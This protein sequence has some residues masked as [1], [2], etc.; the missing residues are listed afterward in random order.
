MAIIRAGKP[1]EKFS[2]VR[3][4]VLQDDRLS[5]R[6]RGVL[7]SILSRPDNWRCS[8]WDLALDGKEGRDA[9]LTALTELEEFGYL[10]RVKR[11]DD[12]GRWSTSSYV[13]DLPVDKS[14][15]SVDKWL[16]SVDK[17]VDNPVDN[18][19]TEVGKPE[20]GKPN[21]ENPTLLKELDK[22]LDKPPIPPKPRTHCE[23][24]QTLL[25]CSPCA[26]DAKLADPSLVAPQ[27]RARPLCKTHT[28][29]MPC[30][31]CAVDFK[32]SSSKRWEELYNSGVIERG[33]S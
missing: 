27:N 2:I 19:V 18:P 28:E 22:K 15:F 6:A 23:M 7:A 8:A 5:Y 29:P 13:F 10:V 26:A 1:N 21:S 17:P 14:T 12:L 30:K 9:I 11:Q 16:E 4:Q 32:L 3:N 33:E 20:S 24:H 25:P 31:S